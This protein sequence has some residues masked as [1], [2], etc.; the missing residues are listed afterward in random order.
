[1]R[2]GRHP[3]YYN[4]GGNAADYAH[5]MELRAIALELLHNSAQLYTTVGCVTGALPLARTAHC[6]ASS[7]RRATAPANCGRRV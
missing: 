6:R 7:S 2:D 4:T 1:M 3:L 5:V